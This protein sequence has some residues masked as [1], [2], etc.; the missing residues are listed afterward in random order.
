MGINKD[1][2]IGNISAMEFTMEFQKVFVFE[3]DTNDGDMNK[4]TVS[5]QEENDLWEEVGSTKPLQIH[6]VDDV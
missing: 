5:Q 2:P 4:H 6:K 1:G 3:L